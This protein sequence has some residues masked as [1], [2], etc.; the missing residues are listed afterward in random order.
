MKI[1]VAMICLSLAFPA[2]GTACEAYKSV[3]QD[4]AQ[5]ML[6]ALGNPKA[7]SL[8]R[9]FA[10][11]TLACSDIPSVRRVAMEQGLKNGNDPVLRGQVLL[12]ILMQKDAVN[13]D[14]LDTP[15]LPPLSRDFIKRRGGSMLYTFRFKDRAQGCISIGYNHEC[16]R[17]RKITIS[18][19]KI[20]ILDGNQSAHADLQLQPDNTLRGLW[21]RRDDAP[22]PVRITLF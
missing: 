17:T 19:D 5:A 9:V 7:K 2:L 8:E 11:Q 16:D 20:Q 10:F 1:T 3:P 14:L 6:D 13:L 12:E 4:Q 21:K 18:G 15:N 22:I